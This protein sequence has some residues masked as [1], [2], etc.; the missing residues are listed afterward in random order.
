MDQNIQEKDT[1]NIKKIEEAIYKF[2]HLLDNIKSSKIINAIDNLLPYSHGIEFECLKKPKYNLKHFQNIPHIMDIDTDNMEQRY[3]IPSGIKG[4][5]C[6]YHICE[7]MREYSIVDLASSN[8]YHTDMTDVANQTHNYYKEN[9]NNTEFQE[10]NNNWII[11]E[12]KSWETAKNYNNAKIDYWYKYNDIG[13]LEIRIGEPTFEYEIIVRRLIQCA[14]LVRKLKSNLD[15]KK[16]RLNK[17]YDELELLKEKKE[18]IIE[19]DD[20]QKIINQR[21]IKI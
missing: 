5:I 3:R 19:E 20:I 15:P 14:N 12:L 10:A 4:L 8:H 18:I 9:R 2:P 6:L 16:Y 7:R 11:E 17:L 13:T 1:D 21:I